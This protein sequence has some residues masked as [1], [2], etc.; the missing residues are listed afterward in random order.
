MFCEI[1]LHMFRMLRSSQSTNES[2]Q[3][4]EKQQHQTD[5]ALEDDAL[6]ISCDRFDA[7]V[8]VAS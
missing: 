4:M 1:N 2:N 5:T 8:G 3:F 6:S 7:D